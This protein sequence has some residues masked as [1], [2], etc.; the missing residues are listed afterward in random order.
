MAEDPDAAFYRF[1]GSSGH[2]PSNVSGLSQ[3]M[4]ARH[5]T[6]SSLKAARYS[7]ARGKRSRYPSDEPLS[8]SPTGAV[9]TPSLKT[10]GRP[11]SLAPHPAWPGAS[12]AC[13]ISGSSRV[14]AERPEAR[15]SGIA[16]WTRSLP[17]GCASNAPLPRRQ[18]PRSQPP[19][20]VHGRRG[21]G[22]ANDPGRSVR[23]LS[24]PVGINGNEPAALACPGATIPHG[25]LFSA[26]S[27]SWLT[28]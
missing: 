19:Q 1:A 12:I 15:I 25:Q 23:I 26:P 14:R 11:T 16:S 5:T 10:R 9:R 6:H 8:P 21:S 4:C 2:A 18:E 17:R 7:L 27:K 13:G 20:E 22:N 3:A 28:H 24:A